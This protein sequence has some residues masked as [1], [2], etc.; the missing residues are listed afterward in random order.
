[1]FIWMIYFSKFCLNA[2][3]LNLS[4]EQYSKCIQKVLLSLPK[5]RTFGTGIVYHKY[6]DK[7]ILRT[8]QHAHIINRIHGIYLVLYGI[9]GGCAES[10]M[11]CWNSLILKS[12]FQTKTAA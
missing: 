12:S 7:Y 9:V 3:C 8:R 4:N 11:N 2:C 5:D 10:N 6:K 1:M